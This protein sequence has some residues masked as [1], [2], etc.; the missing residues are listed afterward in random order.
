M[1]ATLKISCFRNLPYFSLEWVKCNFYCAYCFLTRSD[2][3]SPLI[4][5][6]MSFCLRISPVFGK[7]HNLVLRWAG[8]DR[9]SKRC[10]ASSYL[11][12]C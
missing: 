4:L 6:I 11:C 5:L 1:I 3:Q 8:K 2:V 7:Y 10:A 9:K 12:I